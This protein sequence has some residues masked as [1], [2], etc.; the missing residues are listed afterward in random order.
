[1]QV[2][3]QFL[4]F[5]SLV[6][7]A[8]VAALSLAGAIRR[9]P[10]WVRAAAEGVAAVAWLNVAVALLLTHALVTHDFSNRYVASYSDTTMPMFYLLTAFWAGEK[11]ALLFWVVSLSLLAAVL[12]RGRRGDESAFFGAARS[13]V[14]LALLFFDILMVFASNPFETF[15]TSEGPADGSGMNPLLQNPLM[16]IHPPFQLAGFVAYTVPF[17]FSV[18]ALITGRLDGS[19]IRE[20]RRWNLLA[21]TLLTAG[22]V[23]GGLWAYVELGWGGFWGW[24]P[25]ENAALL[26]WLSGTALLHS[27][28]VEA[29]R[30]MLRRWNHFLVALTFLLTIFATFLTRSQLISSLHAFSN[31]VLT[32]FFVD[33]LTVLALTSGALIAWRWRALAPRERIR[34]LWTREALVV[35]N[36][37]LFLLALF[38]VLWGTLLPKFSESPRVQDAINA[39]IGLWNQVSG[40][41]VPPLRTAI[42]VGPEWFNRVV[43]PVGL[44]I[45]GLTALGPLVPFRTGGRGAVNRAA[46]RTG[47]VSL[48]ATVVVI[49]AYGAVRVLRAS[50]VLDVPWTSAAGTFLGRLSLP[51]AYGVAG[52]LLAIWVVL[53]AARDT[54][55]SV[56][57]RRAVTGASRLRTAWTLLRDNPRRYGGHAAHVGVALCFFSFAGAAV[58]EERKDVILTPGERLT[59]GG[60]DLVLLGT[61]ETYSDAGGFASSVSEVLAWPRGRPVPEPVR[62]MLGRLPSVQALDDGDAPEVVLRLGSAGEARRFFA[63][64]FARTVVARDF[65]V[66]RLD[67]ARR[68]VHLAPARLET[69]QVVPRAFH[70]LTEELREFARAVGEDL[71]TVRSRRG[72]PLLVLTVADEGVFEALA[73]GLDERGAFPVAL[74]SLDANAPDRVRVIP[75]GIGRLLA[76]ETRFYPKFES[77]TTEVDIETGLLYDLYVA[78]APGTGTRS[79]SVTAMVNPL[80]SWLWVGSA[81]LVGFG[82]VLVFA[83]RG[84]R[85]VRKPAAAAEEAA[86]PV[87]AGEARAS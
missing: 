57:A 60:Q 56:A 27:T 79:A 82:F 87:V 68:E 24:D 28:S 22:L 38:I 65:Q 36:S 76:P 42:T 7:T 31:S 80:M 75:S 84:L 61:H 1:M 41:A 11:G 51:A 40:A 63:N 37:I 78:A 26:P 74:A 48:G 59:L 58:R 50:E 55:R 35:A 16:A 12:D 30:G 85:P 83:G 2:L 5:A 49:L 23:I 45:L 13:V 18:A 34:G 6:L 3:G 14:I 53:V 73:G 19:W 4:V 71:V 72:D 86:R 21:W 32:P 17:A 67:R 33:Y 25:V 52:V 10:R 44:L 46:L 69:L 15:L 62:A 70:R 77:P 29:R 39:A 81:V 47:L 9:H 54:V 64:A 8:F 66:V 43:A 20:S